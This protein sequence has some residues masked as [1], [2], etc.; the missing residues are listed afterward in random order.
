[1]G[2]IDAEFAGE[3]SGHYYFKKNFRADSGIIAALIVLEYMAMNGVKLSELREL[4]DIYSSTGEVNFKVNDQE[5]LLK[6]IEQEFTVEECDYLD[7]LTVK[8]E[9]WWFNLRPSNTEPLIRLNLEAKNE[10]I[11]DE[12]LNVL[13]DIIS[14]FAVDDANQGMTR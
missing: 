13:Q 10:T 2:E 7:G 9:N 8:S 4:Y 5:G 11:R 12:K 3:H 6:I 1:M 14:T